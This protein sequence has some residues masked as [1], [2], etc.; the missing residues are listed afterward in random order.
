VTVKLNIG[1][2]PKWNHKGWLNLD[3]TAPMPFIFE[4]HNEFPLKDNSQEIVYSSHA[5]EH[6]PEAV[7]DYVLKESHRVLGDYKDL[8]IK[9]PDFDNILAH[10]RVNDD[11]YFRKEHGG[12]RKIIPTWKSKGVPDT[13]DYRCSMIFCG[14]WNQAYGDHFSKKIK[15]H[16]DAYHGP[17][18]MSEKELK[19]LLSTGKP[20]LISSTLRAEALKQGDITFNHQTAWGKE[21]FIEL[22]RSHGFFI[23][24]HMNVEDIL[25]E[26][27]FIPGINEMK[28]ISLFVSSHKV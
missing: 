27:S 26:Y 7:V 16:P 24:T 21:E 15:K 19:E 20:N 5:L 2:G 9:I 8:V 4:K 12:L 18:P 25:K 3:A 1:G 22:L 23:R 11:A 10:W 13:I 14:F 17:V 28:E 6:L